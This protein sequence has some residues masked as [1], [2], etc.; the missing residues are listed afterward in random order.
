MDMAMCQNANCPSKTH[1]Y[2]FIAAPDCHQVYARFTVKPKEDRCES[3]IPTRIESS[4]PTAEMVQM[5]LP[6]SPKDLPLD[7]KTQM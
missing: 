1:C 5:D 3:Y 2:R 4:K 6:L 7:T